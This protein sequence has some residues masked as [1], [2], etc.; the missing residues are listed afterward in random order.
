MRPILDP[1]LL[2]SAKRVSKDRFERAVNNLRRV[3]Y[4]DREIIRAMADLQTPINAI[5][6]LRTARRSQRVIATGNNQKQ[7]KA[8]PTCRK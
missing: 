6:S 3:G 7:R 4:S 8:K 5:G 2:V 1:E